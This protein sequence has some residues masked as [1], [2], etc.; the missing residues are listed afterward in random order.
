[1][2]TRLREDLLT[3]MRAK[4]ANEVAV[5][6]VCLAAID[7]AQAVPVGD[8]HQTYEVKAFGDRSVEVPRQVLDAVEVRTVLLRE[9]EDR[10]D[11]A[12]QF[13]QHGS[14]DRAATLRAEAAIISRYL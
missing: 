13:E 5:L 3:A 6:R 10:L 1:M 7:N 12:G 4:G 9:M 14:A 8:K 2:Q 11:G